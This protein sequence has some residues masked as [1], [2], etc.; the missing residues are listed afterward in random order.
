MPSSCIVCGKTKTKG[1]SISM[2]HFPTD[3]SK[4]S[5]WLKA[6][7]LYEGDIHEYTRICSRHFLYGDTSSVLSLCLGKRFVS[8]RNLQLSRGQRSLKRQKISPTPPPKR[9]VIVSEDVS[10]SRS[11]TVTPAPSNTTDES[12]R[13]S[14]VL[15]VS[16]GEPLLNDYSIHDL[17]DEEN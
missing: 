13:M 14:E 7:N 3:P 11:H 12:D 2:H 1:Q 16:I 6:V 15:S 10:S 9:P 5:Q 8:P 4:R 17:P